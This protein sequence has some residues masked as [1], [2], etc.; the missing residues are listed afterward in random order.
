[1]IQLLRK[2]ELV[3]GRHL[4]KKHVYLVFENWVRRMEQRS[5][6]FTM[7]TK[8]IKIIDRNFQWLKYDYYYYCFVKQNTSKLFVILYRFFVSLAES[9]QILCARTSC[10]RV[11]WTPCK[12]AVP[13][14]ETLRLTMKDFWRWGRPCR[15][16]HPRIIGN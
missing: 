14:P 4:K 8:N 5:D 2:K 11:S 15:N 12:A 3:T 13:Q 6:C 10:T 9:C 16:Y 1:M 7:F